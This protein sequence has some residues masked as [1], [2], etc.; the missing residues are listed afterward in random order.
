MSAEW[1]GFVLV[2]GIL[3]G[4]LLS[5]HLK[6]ES[7]PLGLLEESVVR[8][9]IGCFLSRMGVRGWGGWAWNLK[10]SVCGAMLQAGEPLGQGSDAFFL[11]TGCI[12]SERPYQHTA[13]ENQ[14]PSAGSELLDI[15]KI[16][17]LKCLW[18]L[19]STPGPFSHTQSPNHFTW[20]DKRLKENMIISPASV[21][22]A[23]RSL[24]R[25]EYQERRIWR[26]VYIKCKR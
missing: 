23:R 7:K 21:N 4:C 3:L 16:N 15:Q 12:T 8:N 1:E 20:K 19:I 5:I 25:V 11:M 22:T 10:P 14:L 17:E 18:M 9:V 6:S 13:Y 2:R 26:F 24:S